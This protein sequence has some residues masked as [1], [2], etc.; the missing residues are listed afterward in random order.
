MAPDYYYDLGSKLI[1]VCSQRPRPRV[2]RNPQHDLLKARMRLMSWVRM[3]V[4]LIGLNKSLYDLIG[5]FI[6]FYIKKNS[7]FI[8]N[9][10]FK[11]FLE[12]M[13]SHYL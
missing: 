12:K 6:Y 8:L 7:K 5:F 13:R 2:P 10:F 9:R 1:D 4:D 11:M 3:C